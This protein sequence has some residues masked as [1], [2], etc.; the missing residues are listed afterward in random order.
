MRIEVS[1]SRSRVMGSYFAMAAARPA[2]VS[3]SASAAPSA[4]PATLAAEVLFPSFGRTSSASAMQAA[5]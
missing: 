5:F 3:G 1:A 4:L 2:S